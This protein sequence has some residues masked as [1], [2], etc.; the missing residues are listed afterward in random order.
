MGGNGPKAAIS[1]PLSEAQE[2][3]RR[4]SR[5]Y[6]QSQGA[7]NTFVV[8][9]RKN[10]PL[11]PDLLKTKQCCLGENPLFTGAIYRSAPGTS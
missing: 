1:R 6:S 8:A 5:M 4:R 2:A 7:N 10:L 11:D 3:K 9:L